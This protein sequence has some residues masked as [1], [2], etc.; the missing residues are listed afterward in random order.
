MEEVTSVTRKQKL[1][2]EAY[3]VVVGVDTLDS[4]TDTDSRVSDLPVLV[5]FLGFL[6]P[7][8]LTTFCNFVGTRS[9]LHRCIESATVAII[10]TINAL[11][12]APLTDMKHLDYDLIPSLCMYVAAIVL[13]LYFLHDLWHFRNAMPRAW[14]K[15]FVRKAGV[16]YKQ[17]ESYGLRVQKMTF[18]DTKREPPRFKVDIGADVHTLLKELFTY[19]DIG[20]NGFIEKKEFKA[21]I[22]MLNPHRSRQLGRKTAPLSGTSLPSK[23][24]SLAPL[25]V[26]VASGSRR[27]SGTDQGN[28]WLDTQVPLMQ[29]HEVE[30]SM[31]L[32]VRARIQQPIVPRAGVSELLNGIAPSV[33]RTQLLSSIEDVEKGPGKGDDAQHIEQSVILLARSVRE[34]KMAQERECVELRR[35]SVLAMKRDSVGSSVEGRPAHGSIV[36]PEDLMHQASS[37]RT[38]RTHGSAFLDRILSDEAAEQKK[39]EDFRFQTQCLFRYFDKDYDEVLTLAEFMVLMD[40][41]VPQPPSRRVAAFADEKFQVICDAIGQDAGK[42]IDL[43][44]L[45]SC[46]AELGEELQ[47]LNGLNDEDE[48]NNTTPKFS[49]ENFQEA[50]KKHYNGVFGSDGFSEFVRILKKK[51]GGRTMLESR[52]LHTHFTWICDQHQ[53]N[54]R[55]SLD[56]FRQLLQSKNVGYRLDLTKAFAAV[57]R[58]DRVCDLIVDNLGKLADQ[59]LVTARDG[60]KFMTRRGF[61]TL[62]SYKGR[63]REAK[64]KVKNLW[65]PNPMRAKRKLD[66]LFDGLAQSCLKQEDIDND[67]GAHATLPGDRA[68]FDVG[69][70]VAF[71]ILEGGLRQQFELNWDGTLRPRGGDRKKG[72]VVGVSDAGDAVLVNHSDR[73]K[74]A[75]IRMSQQNGATATTLPVTG[76]KLPENRAVK[77]L[78][79]LSHPRQALVLAKSTETVDDNLV[80]YAVLGKAEDAMKVIFDGTYIRLEQNPIQAFECHKSTFT[81]GTTVL[82]SYHHRGY[83]QRFKVNDDGSISPLA[84]MDMV[85]GID[86]RTKDTKRQ[87]QLVTKR[88]LGACDVLRFNVSP[89]HLGEP[90]NAFPLKLRSPASHCLS[91]RKNESGD[92]C[93]EAASLGFSEPMR[94]FFE[95]QCI[96]CVSNNAHSFECRDGNYDAGTNVTISLNHGKDSQRFVAN[97]DGTI[98][99]LKNPDVVWAISRQG[100]ANTNNIVLAPK[101]KPPANTQTL[102]FDMPLEARSSARTHGDVHVKLVLSSHP[103]RAL[104]RKPQGDALVLGPESNAAS[105]RLT[106]EGYLLD[107]TDPKQVLQVG[108]ALRTKAVTRM[109]LQ[110]IMQFL[111]DN[112]GYARWTEDGGLPVGPVDREQF[113]AY[114]EAHL[115]HVEFGK[116]WDDAVDKLA[117][118][119]VHNKR[120][121]TFDKTVEEVHRVLGPRLDFDSLSLVFELAT[122]LGVNLEKYLGWTPASPDDMREQ[123][124]PAVCKYYKDS[125]AAPGSAMEF[126]TFKKMLNA[127]FNEEGK[128]DILGERA[129][130]TWREREHKRHLCI[131][132]FT[133]TS[134]GYQAVGIGSGSLLVTVRPRVAPFGEKVTGATK[135]GD[136]LEFDLLTHGKAKVTAVTAKSSFSVLCAVDNGKDWEDEDDANARK[137]MWKRFD[138]EC[139]TQ[140][141]HKKFA[142]F[143]GVYGTGHARMTIFENG[144][145]I[146]EL[147]PGYLEEKG[148]DIVF[149]PHHKIVS[150]DDTKNPPALIFKD[151]HYYKTGSDGED[152]MGEYAVNR[153]SANRATLEDMKD[154]LKNMRERREKAKEEEKTRNM[155]FP[156]KVR[157]QSWWIRLCS[158]AIAKRKNSN[159]S[160]EYVRTSETRSQDNCPATMVY[161]K[162]FRYRR[163]TRRHCARTRIRRTQIIWNCFCSTRHRKSCGIK[164]P[165]RV[166][167]AW[168]HI[169]C[170]CRPIKLFSSIMP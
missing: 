152:N 82:L 145:V 31:S 169:M 157:C 85:L 69:T 130:I 139:D 96:V 109:H 148:R 30:M 155:H 73:Y 126:S 133:R 32:S 17:V 77:P 108:T 153:E 117:F 50:I 14:L 42:G 18:A 1:R 115:R 16:Q 116:T 78:C 9:L 158:A 87:L 76:I 84:N 61:E 95:D 52:F 28:A 142:K 149:K 118:H 138:E 135:C 123:L 137:E 36:D 83:S 143:A 144:I 113:H 47:I 6:H 10:A 104:V 170:V 68:H 111:K 162:R 62:L 12:F 129:A 35:A 5:S 53:S 21:L 127:W 57:F 121:T 93:V 20:G 112:A 106:N 67:Y 34:Q 48:D 40:Q 159:T 166:I 156:D 100:K 70:P 103:K 119:Y 59:G 56:T 23:L 90:A 4:A 92:F 134:Q 3:T 120:L 88:A 19:F 168:S 107:A 11:C 29:Y 160:W 27:L 97:T 51:D 81:S 64:I 154:K 125:H 165:R 150:I 41:A 141:E 49:V 58:P 45:L 167:V 33:K 80:E 110:D 55:I 99:P 163:R 136:L 66:E 86:K 161:S 60:A 164:R 39:E 71:Y 44:G 131:Q 26:T 122:E 46:Y 91:L 105:V 37:T 89:S 114:L 128:R 75:R 25:R 2:K 38:Q 72:L 94:V 102:V 98:S 146:S 151:K 132:A 147:F 43:D 54:S 124:W 74:V 22:A 13:T 8:G 63:Q 101:L 65:L 79:L 140:S 24:S 7:F 15:R